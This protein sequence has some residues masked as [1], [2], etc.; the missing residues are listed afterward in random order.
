ML[1]ALL[2]QG[3]WLEL[4]VGSAL[5][6]APLRQLSMKRRLGKS[7]LVG[8]RSSA[9]CSISTTQPPPM[10]KSGLFPR[11]FRAGTK[12]GCSDSPNR[13]SR[14]VVS[15]R[16]VRGRKMLAWTRLA[17][18][19][20]VQRKWGLGNFKP[21]NYEKKLLQDFMILMSFFWPDPLDTPAN[22]NDESVFYCQCQ[23]RATLWTTRQRDKR[24]YHLMELAAQP[25][26]LAC[27]VS[28]F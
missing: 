28:F 4:L 3:Q 24:G 14:P 16:D 1:L 7:L 11:V 17:G 20:G 10:G 2:W 25:E 26:L 9:R 27:F 8:M 12:H 5:S 15:T 22:P 6:D 18:G 21:G 13:W 19:C 23:H